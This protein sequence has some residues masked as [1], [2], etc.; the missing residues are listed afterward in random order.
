MSTILDTPT[1][2]TKIQ[3][4]IKANG[5]KEI[6]GPKMQE[7]LLDVVNSFVN[8]ITNTDFEA[9]K[10][11]NPT[12]TYTAGMVTVYN[13]NSYVANATTTGTFDSEAWD[14]IGHAQ[15][16]DTKL[17]EGTEF[18]VTAAQIWGALQFIN[19]GGVVQRKVVEITGSEL[20]NLGLANDGYGVL[21]HDT[22]P[23]TFI[24]V[25]NTPFMRDNGL[26]FF[27]SED[28]PIS[29]NTEFYIYHGDGGQELLYL[30]Q[31]AI[32]EPD[33]NVNMFANPDQTVRLFSPSSGAR[34]VNYT[35]GDKLYWWYDKEI[36]SASVNPDAKISLHFDYI[37]R[38]L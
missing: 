6:T 33:I 37:I 38:E 18:E 11:Y 15:N 4:Q 12:K 27:E 16:T 8:K 22:E 1:L 26:A 32:A 17:A 29:S 2:I 23:G 14:I 25:V 13:G 24:E 21:L 36:L 34:N 20:F 35:P 19:T 7:I 31:N 3:Q 10:I 30:A 28:N 9:F 5:N